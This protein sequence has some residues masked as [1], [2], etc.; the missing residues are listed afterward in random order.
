[1]DKDDI[2]DKQREDIEI[3]REEYLDKN[4]SLIR[5]NFEEELRDIWYVWQLSEID[6]WRDTYQDR[7]KQIFITNYKKLWQSKKK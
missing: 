7:E 6:D 5:D 3:A 1:M 2:Y 4:Y